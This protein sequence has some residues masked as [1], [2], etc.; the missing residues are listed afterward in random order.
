MNKFR[1]YLQNPG[2][3]LFYTALILLGVIGAWII[4]YATVWGVGFID[5]DSFNY[6]A[7][8]RSLAQGRGFMY[9][10]DPD[11]YAPLTNFPPIYPLILSIFELV[12]IDAVS[13][14]RYLN[15]LLFGLSSVL[16]GITLKKETGSSIFALLGAFLI[17]T[18]STLV[19]FYSFALAEGLYLFFTLLG[20]LFLIFYIKTNK[21]Y[22]LVLSGLIIGLAIMTRY[23]GVANMLTAG[24][25]LLVYRKRRFSQTLLDLGIF[26]LLSLGPILLWQSREIPIVVD[27]NTAMQP[28]GI[29]G[30][31][32]NLIFQQNFRYIYL[33][34]FYTLYSW[35]LPEKLYLGFEEE[36]LILALAGFLTL[37]GGMLIYGKKIKEDAAYG[38]KK[39][40]N[41]HPTVLV[42]GSFFLIYF[43]VVIGVT[44]VGKVVI[45]ERVFIPIFL[46]T[47]I[48]LVSILLY[49][50]KLDKKYLRVITGL[51]SAYLILF[52][53]WSFVENVPAIHN[54]GLGLGRKS[55]QNNTSMQMLKELSQDRTI[56]SN[57]PWALY[58][59]TGEIGY[60]LNK[61]LPEN[62]QSGDTIIAIFSYESISNPEFA[63]KH[64]ESFELLES[65]RHIDVYLFKP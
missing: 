40:R 64:S 9:P 6:I 23:V 52:S 17:I 27:T 47:T 22:F 14:A 7:V 25:A 13:G 10:I 63:A 4:Y 31:D 46:S 37:L 44:M 53:M 35:Y 12:N 59:H 62:A 54:K 45:I 3:L 2:T 19:F 1:H 15:A 11:T 65:D 34:I 41:G 29:T 49:L 21:R 18:S 57:Y 43:G 39:I 55:F 58:L 8:A 38:L 24:L 56:Y 33:I 26:F 16:V 48:I 20:F 50:W 60:R 32:I 30:F 51:V 42:Y 36:H 5:W 28:S 61:F